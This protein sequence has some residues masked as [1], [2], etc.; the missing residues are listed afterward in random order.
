MSGAA[1]ARPWCCCTAPWRTTATGVSS[2]T[3]SPATSRW[4]PGMHRGAD[5]SFDPPDDYG[6]EGY[7]DSL[8]AFIPRARPRHAARHGPLLRIRPRARA[9]SQTSRLRCAASSLLSGYAGVGRARSAARRPNERRRWGQS[10]KRTCRRARYAR[11]STA[12]LF[13]GEG[14]D[15][16]SLPSPH[17]ELDDGLP[18]RGR[19]R[20]RRTRS[21]MR[22]CARSCRRSTCPTLLLHGDAGP[23]RAH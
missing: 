7:A 13:N 15:G 22:I 2:S 5:G 23:A 19:A 9:V 10:V 12:T 1:Q 4:W 3:G 14:P 11:T 6:L 17:V 21:P 20:D 18:P 16:R 8:A